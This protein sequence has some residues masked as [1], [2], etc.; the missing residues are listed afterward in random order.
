MSKA[1]FS[2]EQKHS[3]PWVWLI[4][5]PVISLIIY[6]VIYFNEDGKINLADKGD[7]TGIIIIGTVFFVLMVG[8]TTLFYKMKLTTIISTEGI[9][10]KFPPIVKERFISKADICRYELIEYKNKRGR[11]K[12]GIKSRL[13]KSGKS[14]TVSAKT[15]LLMHL[16]N[17]K[18]VLV[19]TD[20]RQA[21]K[22]AMEK[23]L[24][25]KGQK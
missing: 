25:N 4:I 12:S 19:D 24:S 3:H 1:L 20:R 8:L 2:E 16:T 10:I 9:Y 7:R 22:S 11:R 15:G 13:Q 14:Y 23:M 21:I 6:F 17:E 5:F 18:K